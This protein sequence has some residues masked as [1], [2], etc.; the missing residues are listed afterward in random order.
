MQGRYRRDAAHLDLDIPQPV[1]DEGEGCLVRAHGG[2]REGEAHLARLARREH[3]LGGG[4][5]EEGR[6]EEG[7]VEVDL[8]RVRVRVRVRVG[9]EGEGE[10]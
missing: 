4:G 9:G 1:D 8:V 6:A 5:G 3:A 2:R 10:G 7:H